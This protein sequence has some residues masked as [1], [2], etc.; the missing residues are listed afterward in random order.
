[1]YTVQSGPD[2]RFIFRNVNSG[3][4]KLVVARVGG[5]FTPYEYGQRGYL[6]RG[7]T[8]PIADGEAKK[9]FRLEMAPVGTITGRVLDADNRPVGHVAVIA[10]T[11][12]YR[13]GERV[14]TMLELVH[15]DD[16]GEYRLF[17]LTPGRYYVAARLEDLT[18]RTVPLG[19]YPPGRML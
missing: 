15:S 5:G 10:M 11:P 4:Y 17:S 7:V 16:H 19:Y 8:F 14:V 2:G 18:R 3:N 12:I 1:P 9:D 6:G 13:N